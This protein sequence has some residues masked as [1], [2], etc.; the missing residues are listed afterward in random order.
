MAN[1]MVPFDFNKLVVPSHVASFFEENSNIQE[2]VTVP[3]LSYGGKQWAIHLDGDETKLTKKN[4]DGDEEPLTIMR[5]VI[6]DYAKRRGRAYYEGAYNPN[7]P[8]KPICWSLDGL[9]PHDTVQ[10]KPAETCQ[11]CPWSVKG[12]KVNEQGKQVTACSQHRM[13]ALVPANRLD[14]T[15]LRMKIAITSDYDGQSPD[16]QAQGW[17]AFSN[18]I[19]MLRSKGLQHTGAVVTKMKFDP[20]SDWPKVI[21]SPDRWLNDPEIA[22]V[23]TVI[24]SDA[25]KHLIDGTWSATG[26][27]GEK[28][29][30]QPAFMTEAVKPAQVAP[31]PVVRPVPVEM[32]KP[33]KKPVSEPPKIVKTAPTIDLNLDDDGPVI[34]AKPEP[35]VDTPKPVAK[36]KEVKDDIADLLAEWGEDD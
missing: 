33:V 5:V 21:F 22:Q 29:E 2:R 31:K 17:F 4:D 24:S 6:L 10:N 23:K 25:V 19:D 14:F 18:Y 28:V 11:A 32:P 16:L 20:N 13:L 9:K 30:E 3:S 12:S 26:V 15:P 8:G 1:E 34:E 36:I 35:K 27:D 7:M